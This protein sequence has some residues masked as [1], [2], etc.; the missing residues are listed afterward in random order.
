MRCELRRK[1]PLGYRTDAA[2]LKKCRKLIIKRKR[3]GIPRAALRTDFHEK[4][5]DHNAL[6]M[7]P[8]GARS[9]C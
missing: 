8:F 5:V 1:L 3:S 7:H 9:L 2:R 4:R 6:L